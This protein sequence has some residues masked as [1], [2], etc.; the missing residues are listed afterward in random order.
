[1]NRLKLDFSLESASERLDFTNKYLE[2]ISFEPNQSE[3]E[4]L[5]NYLLW[6]KDEKGEAVGAEVGLS[7]KWVK[8][9]DKFE[10]LEALS[11]S[12]AFSSLSF[13][14]LTSATP[15]KRPR[16]QFSRSETRRNAPPHI[17][18]AFE[19]LWREI[20]KADLLVNLYE[21][22]V[23]KRTDPPREELL[24]RFTTD[25]LEALTAKAATLSQFAYLKLR[26][27]LIEM[28]KEQFTFQD[29]YKQTILTK[30][31]FSHERETTIVFGED[32]DVRPA[33]LATTP[34]GKLIFAPDLTIDPARYNEEQ[35]GKISHFIW[36]EKQEKP[37]FSFTSPDDIYA[38]YFLKE[39]LL[40]DIERQKALHNIESNLEDLL[41]TLDFYERAADL[42]PAQR[43][44]LELKIKHK[45]NQDIADYING[46]YGKSYTANYISTI[47]KQKIVGKI[48]EVAQLHWD[49]VRDVFFEE[50]FKKCSSCGRS[51]L[52]DERNWVRKARS[53]DGFQSKCKRCEREQRKKKRGG[54]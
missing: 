37:I 2:E 52:L 17:L 45:R 5:S 8:P 21:E 20:D 26:H 32:I 24:R 28:R 3:L 53:K 23:G 38:L 50:N 19:T 35:L 36:A 25:D 46:K 6:G 4:T 16:A 27:E 42:T 41:L 43:E 7:T 10:S 9:D 47:F 33:G 51:L 29:L 22:R 54:N 39:D 12:P 40:D 1:M 15:L 31:T 13:K 14:P 11:E 48:C 30:P 49:S 18:E 44:I 34:V